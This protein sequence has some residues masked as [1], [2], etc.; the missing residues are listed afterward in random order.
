MPQG[1]LSFQY[2]EEKNA[3]GMTSLGGLPLYVDLMAGMKLGRWIER[4]VG[5]RKTQGWSDASMVESLVLLNIAG[6]ESVED[7]ER[8]EADEGFVRCLKKLTRRERRKM[9]RKWRK[10]CRRGI[11][12]ATAVF[13]YLSEFHEAEE[14]ARRQAEGIGKAFILAAGRIGG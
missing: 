11:P 1:L 12:S 2:E 3:G 7:L 6:G 10:E 14:E 4:E 9:A 5:L 8:L 13:R